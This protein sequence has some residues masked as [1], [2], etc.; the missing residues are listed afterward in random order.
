MRLGGDEEQRCRRHS[1]EEIKAL[2]AKYKDRSNAQFTQHSKPTYSV[3][4][5]YNLDDYDYIIGAVHCLIKIGVRFDVNEAAGD[6]QS[7][8]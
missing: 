6:K 7:C 3:T 5:L 4:A 1:T 8:H 2:A